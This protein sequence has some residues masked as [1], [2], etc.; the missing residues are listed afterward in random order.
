MRTSDLD[1]TIF[2]SASLLALAFGGKSDD[3][4][5]LSQPRPDGRPDDYAGY[6]R[7][8]DDTVRLVLGEDWSYEGKVAG[9]RRNAKGTYRPDGAGLLLSDE[10]GLRTRVEPAEYGLE[11]AG[12]QLFKV[13]ER[14]G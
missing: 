10:S 5:R 6:W 2:T 9:R 12:H 1:A 7:N 11:M 8:A 14:C 3:A 13:A 4:V